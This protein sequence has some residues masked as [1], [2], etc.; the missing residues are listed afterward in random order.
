[1]VKMVNFMLCIFTTIKR[2]TRG[3]SESIWEV[4]YKTNC[5]ELNFFCL[6]RAR[7]LDG[8]GKV[9]IGKALQGSVGVQ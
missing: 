6:S 2:K 9:R 8:C 7:K 3:K 4:N 5:Q 1:M